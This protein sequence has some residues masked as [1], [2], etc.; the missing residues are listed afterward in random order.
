MP[1]SKE[2]RK[3]R[4]AL[5]RTREYAN[6]DNEDSKRQDKILDSSCMTNANAGKPNDRKENADYS[7]HPLH[8]FPRMKY[9][10]IVA[11]WKAVTHDQINVF[12]TFVIAAA[13]VIYAIISNSTLTEIKTQGQFAQESLSIS[14]RAYVTIGRKDGVV[15]DFVIPKD[16][17]QNAEVVVYFQNSGHVPAKFTWGTIASLMPSS[18][19]PTGITYTHPYGAF[20]RIRDRKTGGVT[21][22]GESTEIAGDSVVVSTLGTISQKDLADLPINKTGV[23]VIGMYEYC[24]ELGN[25]SIRNFGLRYRNNAPSTSLSFDLAKDM[26]IPVPLLPPPSDPASATEVI[27]PCETP[28]ERRKNAKK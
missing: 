8:D 11:W 4:R 10:A 19:K 21:E 13:T 25:L 5:E 20:S 6:T 24:D 7:H 22:Q 26:A 12:F 28:Q 16:P 27:T 23:L 15:A 17:N 9:R 1:N 14:Q 2:R 18:N 3:L